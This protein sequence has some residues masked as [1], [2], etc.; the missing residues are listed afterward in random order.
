MKL[1]CYLSNGYPSIDASI[2]MASE[3]VNAGCDIIEVDFPS[4]DPYLEGELIAGRMAEALRANDNYDD[5]IAGILKIKAQHPNTRFIVLAY[6]NT[7]MEIGVQ[8]YADFILNNGFGEIIYVGTQHPEVLRELI[9][10][11][12]HA[13]CYVQFHQPEDEVQAAL[14]AN[15]FV[16]VQA[17]PTTGNVNPKTPTLKDCIRHLRELGI[18]R[19]IYAGVGIYTTDD[20]AMARDAGA[21][22]VFVGSTILKL[23]DDLPKLRETIRALKSAAED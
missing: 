14:S 22:G 6:E 9:A 10:R 16:Y 21:D 13:S 5:Y 8:K 11:G 12:I 2:R 3:Y 23:H 19:E 20:I 18:T 4:R 1:I 17:K 15:G 7:V